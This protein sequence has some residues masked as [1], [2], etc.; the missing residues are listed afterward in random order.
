ML[1]SGVDRILEVGRNEA[2][3]N[4]LGAEITRGNSD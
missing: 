3:Q 1:E 2:E 4:A